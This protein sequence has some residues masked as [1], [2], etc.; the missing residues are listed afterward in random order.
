[1]T[2]KDKVIPENTGKYYVANHIRAL[3]DLLQMGLFSVAQGM[4]E[5]F[6]GT[7]IYDQ[8]IFDLVYSMKELNT[9][10]EI[11]HFMGNEYRMKWIR[12]KAEKG[13]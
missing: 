8:E 12:Y 11:D 4:N 5:D 1:M 6:I 3:L 7:D 10:S 2:E 13:K 9:W